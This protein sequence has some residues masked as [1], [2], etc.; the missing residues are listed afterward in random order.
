VRGWH[1]EGMGITDG[2]ENKTRLYLGLGMGMG[3][4]HWEW[5]GMEKDIPAHLYADYDRNGQL[6]YSFWSE[7]ELSHFFGPNFSNRLPRRQ[8]EMRQAYSKNLLEIIQNPQ[9]T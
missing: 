1:Q 8:S 2:N 6:C 7:T 3:M 5:E 9:K 4:N